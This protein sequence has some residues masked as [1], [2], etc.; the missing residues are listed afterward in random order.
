MLRMTLA[1]MVRKLSTRMQNT[2]LPY[3]FISRIRC[4]NRA[5]PLYHQMRVVVMVNQLVVLYIYIYI[6]LLLLLCVVPF[7][8]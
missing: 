2:I 3:T 7:V 5:M 8:C 1:S 4:H 6:V